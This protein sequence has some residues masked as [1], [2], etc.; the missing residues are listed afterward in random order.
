MSSRHR[1]SGSLRNWG[2]LAAALLALGVVLSAQPW[3]VLAATGPRLA[4][5]DAEAAVQGAW[6]DAKGIGIY[7]YTTDIVQT[8]WPALRVENAGQV[9]SEERIYIEG[10]TDMPAE[11]MRMRLW[12]DDGNVGN[13]E[14]SVELKV[15]DGKQWGRIGTDAWGEVEVGTSL[16]APGNDV[17]GYLAGARHIVEAGDETRAGVTFTRYAFDV[18][19]PAFAEHMKAQLESE[20]LRSGELPPGVDLETPALY[21]DMTGT[22]EI[23]LDDAGLPLRISLDVLFPATAWEQVEA[24]IT[25]DFAGWDAAA[26]ASLGS[27]LPAAAEMR[28]TAQTFS[29]VAGVVVLVAASL[30]WRR[31]R[32]LYAGLVA[33]LVFSMVVVPLIRADK[34]QA[35]AAEQ[36][37]Q[38]AAYDQDVAQAEAAREA[39]AQVTA[40][41][42]DPR[43]NPLDAGS[44][45]LDPGA[46][47]SAVPSSLLLDN[48]A[49]INAPEPDRD[50]DGLTDAEEADACTESGVACAAGDS[51]CLAAAADSDGDGLSDGVEVIDLGTHPCLADT[52]GDM[53]DDRIEVE[54]FELHGVQWYLDPTAPDTNHDGISDTSECY[55]LTSLNLGGAQSACPDT[56]GDGDPDPF[57]V[58]DDGDGVPDNVDLARTTAVGGIRDGAGSV[59]G[60]EDGALDLDL[61]WSAGSVDAPVFVDLQYRP[62]DPDHLWYSL[63]VLDWPAGDRDGQIKRVLDTTFEDAN[64]ALGHDSGPKDDEGDM[65]L[66]PMLEIE[67]PYYEADHYGNLPILA[68]A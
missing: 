8:T 58:D 20:M 33:I 40:S 13:P 59:T 3:A 65:R 22:G 39:E 56:D 1:D 54:G 43:V 62:T 29:F 53:I 34:V 26:A 68:G 16:F 14:G 45:V 66:I 12:S 21:A 23:W 52:D 31:S 24:Q 51:A 9:A 48:A 57:D 19:G 44:P 5:S 30:I 55:G 32:W 37:A 42:F 27:W 38:Q 4:D 35:F 46:V 67:I 18:D 49:V 41:D 11:T 28:Q 64:A 10:E 36:S 60:L 50:G 47:T 15:E 63:S 2:Y 25:T 61:T 6:R 17:L 7:R